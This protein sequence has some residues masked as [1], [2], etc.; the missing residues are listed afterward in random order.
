MK[1]SPSILGVALF[2][3][4]DLAM[5]LPPFH[6]KKVPKLH[7]DDRPQS[8]GVESLQEHLA[9]SEK[10][11]QVAE[12][13]LRSSSFS[14]E[15]YGNG[16]HT[17]KTLFFWLIKQIASW[18]VS[19]IRKDQG[20]FF[21]LLETIGYFKPDVILLEDSVGKIETMPLSATTTDTGHCWDW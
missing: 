15:K 2:L 19:S 5:D 3:G 16:K 9:N 10:N 7:R 4:W 21:F 1:F 20:F 12:Q 6:P 13:H 11:Q 17:K 8:R 14:G 18:K